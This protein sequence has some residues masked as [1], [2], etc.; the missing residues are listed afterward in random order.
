MGKCIKDFYGKFIAFE[1]QFAAL[2]S[3]SSLH[4]LV[5]SDLHEGL[6]QP[7]DSRA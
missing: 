1:V 6:L 2:R 3:A 4:G 5:N 7:S